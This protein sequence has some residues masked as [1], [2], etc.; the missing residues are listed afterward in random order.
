MSRRPRTR[1]LLVV[2][3]SLCTCVGQGCEHP[4]G[5][6]CGL[7]HEARAARFQAAAQSALGMRA[8]E[9]AAHGD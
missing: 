4:P 9:L 5:V 6:T 1:P 7:L 2:S 3:R 8:G